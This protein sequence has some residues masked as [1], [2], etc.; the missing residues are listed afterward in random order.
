MWVDPLHYAWAALMVNQFE[1]R[2]LSV[3]GNIE[4]RIRDPAELCPVGMAG[5]SG[6]PRIQRT[7]CT[8]HSARLVS[9]CRGGAPLHS[10]G[11]AALVTHTTRHTSGASVAVASYCH[12]AVCTAEGPVFCGA[13]HRST[14]VALTVRRRAQPTCL[15]FCAGPRILQLALS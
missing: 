13:V 14:R 6:S 2:N 11:A 9:V 3:E 8:M 5:L 1:G 12:D 15:A 7:P 4:A 10:S